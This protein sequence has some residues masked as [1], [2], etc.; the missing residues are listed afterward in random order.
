MSGRIQ[1]RTA[2]PVLVTGASAGLGLETALYLAEQGLPV[3]ATVRDDATRQDVLRAAAERNVGLRVLR[4]DLTDPASIDQAVRTVVDEAGGIYALVNNGGIGLRGCLEDLSDREVRHLFETNVLGTLAVTR[5]VLPHMRR[6]GRG[7]VV[8]ISSVGGRISSFGV[9]AYCATKFAQEGFGEA[10]ALEVA[11]FGIRS[12]LIEPGMI[13]TTRWT[14]NRGVAAGALDPGSPYREMFVAAEEVADRIVDRSR[15]RPVDVA[16]A[17]HRAITAEHPR[18]RYVVGR[19]ASVVIRMRRFL[20]EPLFERVYFGPF[21]RR[22]RRA[23]AGATKP[24]A[25]PQ[26]G[27]AT[28]P[29]ADPRA[30]AR[31]GA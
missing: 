23:H 21:L 18:M 3:H 7:R 8:T 14:T 12:V 26:A 11:P 9:G 29:P 22:L 1:Q 30:G 5:A 15:T 6:A 25:D 28:P 17:V 19:P 13:K 31:G 10:L 27:D 20:P 2:G 24:P 16:K 4:L